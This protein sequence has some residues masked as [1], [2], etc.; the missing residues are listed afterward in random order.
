MNMRY[1]RPLINFVVLTLSLIIFNLSALANGPFGLGIVLGGPTGISA[2]YL[3]S[4]KNSLTGAL[5]W[6]SYGDG[7]QI[8]G[9]YLWTNSNF[10]KTSANSIEGYIGVGLRL[11]TWSGRYCERFG[12]CYDHYSGT[13][14]GMRVPLGLSYS[15]KPYPFDIFVEVVPTLVLIPG[16]WFGIDA[17]LGGRFYF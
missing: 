11:Q 13:G 1:N 16:T 6:R 12:R 15:F 7:L 17:A 8:Q 2:R 10:I 3:L 5:A 9:D 14:F 4:N